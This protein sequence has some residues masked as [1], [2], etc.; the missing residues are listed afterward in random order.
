VLARKGILLLP[1]ILTNAG[2]VTVS[3][4]EW[5]QDLQS[6]FWSEGEVNSKLEAVMRRAFLEVHEMARKHRTHMRT[7]AYVLSVGR[8]SEATLARGLF[9]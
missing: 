6:F 9:P 7:G 5:V 3:Y 4:F 8:V 1:D 2:G